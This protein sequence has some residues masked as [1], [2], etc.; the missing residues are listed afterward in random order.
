MIWP[1]SFYLVDVG[2]S[3]FWKLL[4]FRSCKPHPPDRKHSVEAEAQWRNVQGGEK[5]LW[6]EK[7]IFFFPFLPST[8]PTSCLL[9]IAFVS[10]RELKMGC[11][12]KPTILS[13]CLP[14]L[15][16]AEGKNKYIK[17]LSEKKKCSVPVCSLLMTGEK[18]A[19]LSWTLA[20]VYRPLKESQFQLCPC[21][22]IF[23]SKVIYTW[24]VSNHLWKI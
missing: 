23:S 18:S 17:N 3:K 22:L 2:A 16:G 5:G 12:W 15:K 7:K 1:L 21:H 19:F 20:Q 8:K 11:F 6:Y 14:F 24:E 9:D 10:R 4:Y 13:C